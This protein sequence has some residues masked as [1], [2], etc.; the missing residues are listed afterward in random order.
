MLRGSSSPGNC[1]LS[2]P[3]GVPELFRRARERGQDDLALAD[4]PAFVV[5]H[6][7]RWSEINQAWPDIAPLFWAPRDH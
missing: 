7:D 6:D 2:S 5:G 3:G 1:Q 4:H